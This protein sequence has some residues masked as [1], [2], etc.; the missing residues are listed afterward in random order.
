MPTVDFNRLPTNARV[1]VFASDRPL[2]RDEAGVLLEAVDGFLSQWKAHGA[3]LRSARDWRDDRFLAIGVD[4][5]AEQASGCSIDGLFRNLQALE[6]PLATG[7]V[8]GGRVFYRDAK[9]QPAL[10]L[11]KEV[12]ALFERGVIA[13]DTPVFDTS[14][15]DATAWRERFERPARETWVASLLVPAQP[16]QASSRSATK[17]SSARNG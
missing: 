8:Q 14:I 6:G 16:S 4:P 3:P 9:G 11:R 1:W 10:A 17:S 12:P 7:L 5:T 2:S 13:D 15:T